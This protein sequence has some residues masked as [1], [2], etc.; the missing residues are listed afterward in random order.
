MAEFMS[1]QGQNAQASSQE[2][3]LLDRLRRLEGN[4]SGYY[5]IH[6]VLS[7]LTKANQQSHF[8]SIAARSFNNLQ[9][10]Y[11]I[12][13]FD[14]SNKDLVLLCRNVPVDDIDTA[15]DHVRALFSEDPLT[16]VDDSSFE[17]KFAIWY[18]LSNPEDHASFIS[19]A[20]GISLKAEKKL[21]EEERRHR[22]ELNKGV[23]MDPAMVATIDDKLK[24]IRI[25]DMIR[26]Q[27]CLKLNPG[28][29]GGDI[30]FQETFISMNDLRNAVAPDVN[31]FSSP[32]L[33]QF[34]SES[35]DRR[36]LGVLCDYEFE[37]DSDTIS[38]NLNISSILSRD[39][40]RF[41]KAVG[42]KVEKVIIEIQMIDIFSD[43]SNFGYA[44]DSLQERGYRVVVDGLSPLT[45]QFFDPAILKSDYIKIGWGPELEGEES[46]HRK[47]EMRE[48]I[49]HAGKESIILARVDTEKAIKWGIGMGIS[50]FQGFFIDK[51][52]EVVGGSRSVTPQ[53]G[54]VKAAGK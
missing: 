44:R 5:V 12:Q 46:D 30:L 11:D 13:L 40:Q 14:M 54:I 10:E 47:A 48:V 4:P 2:S 8:M 17:D 6:I 42:K 19:V 38:I 53:G 1:A 24:V 37:D 20:A 36:M 3:L 50:R 35:L 18:D 51:L 16:I 15:V 21:Q 31:M 43:M 39:F 27:T 32:W 25:I 23:P 45:L 22:E 52:A 28:G 7:G 26:Q 34:I 9:D 33:F 29:V 49:Q 41:N